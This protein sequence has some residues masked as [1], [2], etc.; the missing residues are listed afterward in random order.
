MS[1][2]ELWGL[3]YLPWSVHDACT[4]HSARR[5]PLNSRHHTRIQPWLCIPHTLSIASGLPCTLPIASHVPRHCASWVMSHTPCLLCP[6]RPACHVPCAPPI[7]SHATSA[8]LEPMK[9]RTRKQ[10]S[11][12]YIAW[13]PN[14]PL[15]HVDPLMGQ[16]GQ[17][18]AQ[19]GAVA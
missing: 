18:A 6:T 16:A 13:S 4:D 11:L 14:A 1:L 3:L 17:I 10:N 5:R 7:L 12:G 9:K 19:L 15:R 8:F 2:H